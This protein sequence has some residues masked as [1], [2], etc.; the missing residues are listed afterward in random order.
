M[1]KNNEWYPNNLDYFSHFSMG[2]GC[3]IVFYLIFIFHYYLF[4]I[5]TIIFYII[6]ELLER[7]F[8][9]RGFRNLTWN[10]E[11]TKKDLISNFIGLFA[12]LS[13]IYLI[14]DFE[15]ILPH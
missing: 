4:I 12:G 8:Y 14:I 11:D 5:L 7:S 6:Y 9:K 2:L 13:L 1:M 3:I 15:T 10:K